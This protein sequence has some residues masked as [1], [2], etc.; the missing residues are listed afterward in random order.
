MATKTATTTNG[1][2]NGQSKD[3]KQSDMPSAYFQGEQAS[4]DGTK[5]MAL[6][7][8]PDKDLFAKPGA[9]QDSWFLTSH[10]KSDRGTLDLLIH[11]LHVTPPDGGAGM[12][13][14]MASLLDSQTQKY[15]AEEQDFPGDKCSLSADKFE[16]ISP[17]ASATGTPSSMTFKG[18]WPTAGIECNV[19]AS[20]TGPLLANNGA[21]L[22]PALG[23][24]TY[25]YAL[26]TMSTTGTVSFGGKSYDING[27][28]WLDRQWGVTPR[29]FVKATKKWVWFSV[30]LDN[31]DRISFWEMIEADRKHTF[32]TLVHPNGAHE[33]AAV[34]PLVDNASRPWKSA[35]TGNVY[36]TSWDVK[37]PQWDGHLTITPKVL[38]QEFISP[39]GAHKY[40]GASPVTGTLHGKSVTGFAVIELVGDWK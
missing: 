37:I 34:E 18:K 2:S 20:Q 17:I 12:V 24:M 25:H 6:F 36:P 1:Q 31:G 8:T 33:V 19:T 5:G 39:S 21:G 30:S 26:P 40:E 7:I 28:S 4:V 9:Q 27:P 35:Q 16:I 11:Y 29:F 22:F 14:I 13:G 15:I 10:L 32:A 38:E 3:T 23:G